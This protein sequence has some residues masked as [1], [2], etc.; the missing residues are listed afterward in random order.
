MMANFFV[1]LVKR[2]RMLTMA[3]NGGGIWAQNAN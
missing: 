2:L 3:D 1:Q